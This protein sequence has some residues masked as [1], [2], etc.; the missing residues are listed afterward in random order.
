MNH[1]L[2]PLVAARQDWPRR[3]APPGTRA[4]RAPI[5]ACTDLATLERWFDRTVDA[6]TV[7]EVLDE[8]SAA[9]SRE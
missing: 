7:E 4:G 2:K 8:P 3:R 6:A 1:R 5:A 9:L